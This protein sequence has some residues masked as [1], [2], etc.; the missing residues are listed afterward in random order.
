MVMDVNQ[1][2]KLCEL[3]SS[4][5]SVGQELLMSTVIQLALK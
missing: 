5:D 3:I 4:E 2:Q 1:L